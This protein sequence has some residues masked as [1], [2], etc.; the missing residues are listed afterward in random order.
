MGLLEGDPFCIL[1]NGAPVTKPILEGDDTV[2]ASIIGSSEAAIFTYDPINGYL[3]S[4]GDY[5][6]RNLIED[7]SLLPKKLVW[8]SDPRVLLP[9]NPD[10]ND[11]G[12]LRF[13]GS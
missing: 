10:E 7:R 8:S 11:S 9:V 12:K 13:S 6:G 2:Q 5:L 1:V 4:N 3:Q